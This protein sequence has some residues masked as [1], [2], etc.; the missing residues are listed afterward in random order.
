MFTRDINKHIQEI[1][2]IDVSAEM[3]S[4]ITDKIIPLIEKW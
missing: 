4:K 3:G 2:G 1:Y